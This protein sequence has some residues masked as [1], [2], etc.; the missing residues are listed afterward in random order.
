MDVKQKERQQRGQDFQLEIMNSWKRIPNIWTMTIKD[1]GGGTR[2]ADRII[3]TQDINIL[4]ELKRTESQRFEL[5]YLRPNQI[6][7]LLDF[8]QVIERNVGLVFIS[9]HST[10][11]GIDTAFAFRLMD[12]MPYMKQAGRSYITLDE[13]RQQVIPCAEMPRGEH[14]TYDLKGVMTCFKSI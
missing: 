8:D 11:K 9:F 1:G 6:K 2:P 13:L 3:L 10:K 4:A 12:A 5:A 14:H 7:G